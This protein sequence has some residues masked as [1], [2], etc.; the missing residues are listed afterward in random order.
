M[1]SYFCIF[2]T[3]VYGQSLRAE[4]FWMWYTVL[5]FLR[6]CIIN[7]VNYCHHICSMNL[8]AQRQPE[9][10]LIWLKDFADFLISFHLIS[11]KRIYG[12]IFK[13]VNSLTAMRGLYSYG[14]R[15]REPENLVSD[16]SNFSALRCL[17]HFRVLMDLT[18]QPHAAQAF[19]PANRS[20][21]SQEIYRFLWNLKV[22]CP[23]HKSP[24]LVPLLRWIKQDHAAHI[25]LLEDS[26]WGAFAKS[27]KALLNLGISVRRSASPHVSPRLQLDG[28]DI[29]Y[30]GISIKKIQILLKSGKIFGRLRWRAQCVLLFWRH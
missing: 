28:F 17:I 16:S 26:F 11:S 19:C 6:S 1:C 9:H 13:H 21:A 18:K 5:S 25:A 27:R 29:G 23:F 7:L 20:S 14:M 15:M 3:P 24:V 12:V 2:E 10:L 22:H 8:S 4:C 30:L